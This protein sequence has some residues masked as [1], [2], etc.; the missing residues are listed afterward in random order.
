RFN[1]KL[2]EAGNRIR[3][4]KVNIIT[5]KSSLVS[6]F[7]KDYQL[8]KV[9]EINNYHH[10]HDAYLNAVVATAL[11]KKYPQLAPE[12]VYGDYPKYNSYKSRKSATERVLFYSNIMNFFKRVVKSSK[13]GTVKI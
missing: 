2:D 9:R 3:D 10:A 6:Q 8:Y 11:L 12:F 4:P 7:R 1:T 13:T 5:L